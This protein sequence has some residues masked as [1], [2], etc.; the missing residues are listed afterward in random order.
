MIINEKLLKANGA[1]L[2]ILEKDDYL[3]RMQTYPQNY[4]QIKN[5]GLKITSN[6]T[7][8][9]EFIHQILGKGDAVGETF[10]WSETMYTIDAIALNHLSIYT[11]SRDQFFKIL[12]KNPEIM[13]KLNQ[14]TCRYI[15]HQ[16]ELINLIAYSDPRSRIIAVIDHL[17]NVQKPFQSF[18]YEIPYTRKQLASLSGLRTETVIR[19]IKLLEKEHAVKIVD[20]KIFY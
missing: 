13:I 18:Q 10:L 1:Q 11:I 9:H 7:G 4:Y 2:I 16:R 3:L 6:K 14:F 17:K 19:T 12:E 8:K 20:G 5:G 15:N